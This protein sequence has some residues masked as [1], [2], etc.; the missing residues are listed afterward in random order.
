MTESPSISL[1]KMNPSE[2]KEYSRFSFENYILET[3]KSSGVDIQTLKQ[4]VGGPPKEKRYTLELSLA[5]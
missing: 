4:K 5:L 1:Q 3:S 2:F